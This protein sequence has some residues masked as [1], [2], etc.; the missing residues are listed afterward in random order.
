LPI[1]LTFSIVS[2]GNIIFDLRPFFFWNA[3]GGVK[4]G[5]GVLV[6]LYISLDVPGKEATCLHKLR[7]SRHVIWKWRQVADEIRMPQT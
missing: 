1:T 3:N 2:Y 4:Q 7:T 6:N 5:L